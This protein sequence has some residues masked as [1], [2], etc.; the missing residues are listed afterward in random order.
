MGGGAAEPRLLRAVGAVG[1][2]GVFEVEANLVEAFLGDEVLA[3]WS[4]VAAIDEG[5]DEGVRV[6]S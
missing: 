4:E 2:F 5:I 1:V 6:G 3:F